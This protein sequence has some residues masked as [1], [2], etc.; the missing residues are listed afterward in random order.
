MNEHVL[1]RIGLLKTN[2]VAR[3]SCGIE[4]HNMLGYVRYY[5]ETKFLVN[6]LEE[7]IN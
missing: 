7:V 3:L 5:L 6:Y 2:T 1:I 4:H